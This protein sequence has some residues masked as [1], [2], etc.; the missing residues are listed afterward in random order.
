M[1][2]LM[3]TFPKYLDLLKHFW[4]NHFI[5]DKPVFIYDPGNHL[6]TICTSIFHR[7]LGF[8]AGCKINHIDNKIVHGVHIING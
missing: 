6:S 5:P 7:L 1:L 8:K 4:Y 3:K 2:M